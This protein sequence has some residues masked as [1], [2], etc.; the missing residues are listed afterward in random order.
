MFKL[1]ARLFI[2]RIIRYGL[3]RVQLQLC[4]DLNK[5]QEKYLLYERA[6]D[7]NYMFLFT[8]PFRTTSK[9]YKRDVHRHRLAGCQL[10]IALKKLDERYARFLE[11]NARA[12]EIIRLEERRG[13]GT[14]QFVEPSP[15]RKYNVRCNCHQVAGKVKPFVKIYQ[16]Y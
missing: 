10:N 16:I 1:R 6:S 8:V 3:V 13:G 2:S 4:G 9:N 7:D 14:T 5:I 12:S 11:L 15:G